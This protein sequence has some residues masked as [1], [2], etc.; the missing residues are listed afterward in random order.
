MQKYKGMFEA[1]SANVDKAPLFKGEMNRET[2]T[3]LSFLKPGDSYKLRAMASF[4]KSEGV[5]S[6][7]K[8]VLRVKE[9]NWPGY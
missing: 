6:V 7:K 2:S 5:Y 4:S 1:F 3:D 8:T 9:R